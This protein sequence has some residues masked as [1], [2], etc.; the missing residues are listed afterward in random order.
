MPNKCCQ[1]PLHHLERAK[2]SRNKHQ[3]Q[4]QPNLERTKRALTRTRKGAL[5][6]TL[7]ALPKTHCKQPPRSSASRA[8]NINL[9][10]VVG[11]LVS[12]L[13]WALARH[14]CWWMRY[15]HDDKIFLVPLHSVGCSLCFD[16][17]VAHNCLW[18]GYRHDAKI[19]NHHDACSLH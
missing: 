13:L 17:Y 3:K 10:S 11:V 2:Q 12:V 6:C 16:I 14:P 19:I 9:I 8:P 1:Q 7:T 15:H 18:L 4:L 5:I